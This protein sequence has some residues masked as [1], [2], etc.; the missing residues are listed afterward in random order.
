MSERGGGGGGGGIHGGNGGDDGG[1]VLGAA[2]RNIALFFNCGHF[3][4]SL[5]HSSSRYSAYL[6]ANPMPVLGG[7]SRDERAFLAR[8][9]SETRVNALFAQVLGTVNGRRGVGGVGVDAP[10]LSRCHQELSA[11]MHGWQQCCKLEDTPFPFPYAQV[12]SFVLAVF[13][14]SYPLIAA[15]QASG[16]WTQV[17]VRPNSSA[18]WDD[19]GGGIFDGGDYGDDGDYLSTKKEDV[20]VIWLAP[21]LSFVTVLTYF[22]FHEVARELED[23]YLHPPNELPLR[24]WQA[25]FNS[26]LLATW[27]A[28]DEMYRPRTVELIDLGGAAAAGARPQPPARAAASSPMA[29]AAAAAARRRR[30]PRSACTA[31]A[32]PTPSASSESLRSGRRRAPRPWAPTTRTTTTCATATASASSGGRASAAAS[33]PSRRR[34]TCATRSTRPSSPRSSSTSRDT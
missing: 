11:G 31:F 4:R 12:V 29:A 16:K 13:A 7:V 17:P 1:G 9:D 20:H 5:R 8:L 3:F 22:A 21:L 28:L 23:P 24:A 6:N 14:V 34:A 10:V 25:S 18:A 15:S 2:L 26:R 27:E 30:R 19:A 32:R 33:A